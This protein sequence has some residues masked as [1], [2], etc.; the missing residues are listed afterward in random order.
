MSSAW[1]VDTDA[2]AYT[3]RD[4]IL[5]V[6]AEV[7][8]RL[9]ETVSEGRGRAFADVPYAPI[10]T[11]ALGYARRAVGHPLDGFG[12][13]APRV[14]SLRI[15]GC[16]F[17]S[18]ENRVRLAAFRR[19]G[20]VIRPQGNGRREILGRLLPPSLVRVDA[21][22]KRPGHA[23]PGVGEAGGSRV[24]VPGNQVRQLLE[25]VR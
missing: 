16:L 10:A 18:T 1:R 13:L 8:A 20:Q 24:A 17:P 3:A 11:V 2:G 19:K 9:L 15:L 14:E 6:P 22:G 4:V 25:C 23:F 5:A 12:F 21:A 7:L